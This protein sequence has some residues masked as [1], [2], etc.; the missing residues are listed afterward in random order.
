MQVKVFESTDMT[1]GLKKVRKELGPDALILS[2]RTIRNRKLGLLGKSMIEITAAIDDSLLDKV[3]HPPD[4]PGT[5]LRPFTHQTYL[6]NGRND[7]N[8]TPAPAPFGDDRGMIRF[9]SSHSDKASHT[10]RAGSSGNT[11]I[12]GELDNLKS[13]IDRLAGEIR[14]LKEPDPD[15]TPLPNLKQPQ[16]TGHQILPNDQLTNI[17]CENDISDETVQT[18]SEF[19]RESL[20]IKDM[21]NKETLTSF[22]HQTIQGLV[23]VSPL[24][25]EKNGAQQK[26]IALVGPT[27]V[28]KTTTL[29][30][31][32]ARMIRDHDISP[33]FIT[34]DTYRIAAVE[35]LKVYGEIMGIPVDVVISPPQLEEAIARH[36]DKDLILIDTAG[37]SPHDQDALTKLADFFKPEMNIEKNL[38]LSA[39]TRETELLHTISQFGLLGFDKMIFTKIDECSKRG[40]LLN[41]Q[42]KNPAPLACITNGQ[43]VPEDLLDIDQDMVAKL[44]IPPLEGAVP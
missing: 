1:S 3:C 13:M 7:Q 34:I 20:S 25:V 42:I 6:D 43:R 8:K 32:A 14:R 5:S 24:T 36:R 17:L 35:Q 22:L 38:V 2:T 29:A 9:K 11:A 18:I 40:V 10:K 37:R 28:G 23:S 26:R 19:V 16:H 41:I 12:Q 39:V 27:G 31:I 21:A 30:K 44:I 33:A 15:H 4:D